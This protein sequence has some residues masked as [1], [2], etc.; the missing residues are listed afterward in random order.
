MKFRLVRLTVGGEDA[1]IPLGWKMIRSSQEE[2]REG[3]YLVLLSD[4]VVKEK[5]SDSVKKEDSS[6]PV[7]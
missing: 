2:G 1:E 3:S 4:T 5:K 6:E 7:W